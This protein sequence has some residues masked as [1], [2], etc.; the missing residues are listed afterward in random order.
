MEACDLLDPLPSQHDDTYGACIGRMHRRIGTLQPAI[1]PHELVLVEP[2]ATNRLRLGRNAGGR[3][4]DEAEAARGGGAV[5]VLRL[6]AP[7]IGGADIA[8]DMIGHGAG[9]ALIDRADDIGDLVRLDLAGR[10]VGPERVGYPV[11][12]FLDFPPGPRQ[13]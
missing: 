7:T 11:E 10:A 6:H 3:V 2:A 1:E 8:A 4:V 5:V 9:A 12:D 13:S